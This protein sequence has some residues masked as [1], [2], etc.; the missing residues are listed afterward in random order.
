MRRRAFIV[1]LAGFFFAAEP[2]AA[3]TQAATSVRRIG[4]LAPGSAYT[5]EDM[6]AALRKLGWIEGHNVFFEQRY[7]N[8]KIEAL[9]S[10]AEEL[11]RLKVE[12]IVTQGTA[13]TL[14]AKSA[15]KTIP[16][17]FASAGDPVRSGLVASLAKPG[18]NVTGYTIVSSQI[19]AKRLQILRD[20]LP[21]VQRVGVLENSTNPYFRAAR[22]DL[23]QAAR[24]LGMQPIFIEVAA[25]SELANAVAE[26]ARRGGQ[27]LLVSPD[28]LFTEN[29]GELMQ[30]ALKT[31]IARNRV[32]LVHSG[33][34][35]VDLLFSRRSGVP[36]PR[37][38]LYR[39]NLARSKTCGSSDRAAK[40]IR[41]DYQSEN[42]QR[43]RDHDTA[44]CVA[45]CR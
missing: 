29:R 43:A 42:G 32:A 27:A 15:T 8:G 19:D 14:A 22:D 36:R 11:V 28:D 4:Y 31:F 12:I 39:P 30:A 25:A 13:A 21:S 7:A 18:S 5:P 40:Q 44:I 3:K 2:Y 10:L 6:Y 45:A 38:G 16:I 37:R 35:R 33:G 41:T 17:V 23:G 26:I 24:S 1:V 34:R 20:L 9:R